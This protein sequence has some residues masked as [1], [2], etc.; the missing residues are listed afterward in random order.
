LLTSIV[1]PTYNEDDIYTTLSR[2]AQQ[3]IF[4]QQNATEIVLADY[5]PD[6]KNLTLNGYRKFI[7]DFQIPT[8][9]V[10][11]DRKGIGY[12]RDRG[13]INSNGQIIVNFDADAYYSTLDGIQQ[14]I[15]PIL[16]G[17][18]VMT[19]CD[20]ILNVSEIDDNFKFHENI[21][22]VKMG[23]VVSNSLQR[24]APIVSLE[25][26]MCFTR[27]A[28]DYVGGFSDIKQSEGGLLSTKIIYNFGLACKR[29]VPQTGVVVSARRAIASAKH[30]IVDCWFN[31][32]NAF[33]LNKGSVDS[34]NL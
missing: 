31:Y 2:L 19:C 12:A 17:E 5:D 8:T 4:Q 25:P 28:Y 26:G 13:I 20:N 18:C 6:H 15:E 29:H 7:K 16:R 9:L 3:T 1:I 33:R 11:V 27:Y 10:P 34:F 24:E 22:I 32:D 21:L 30:G 23:Y 14:S